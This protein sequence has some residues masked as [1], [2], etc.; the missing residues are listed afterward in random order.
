MLPD[1]DIVKG[2]HPGLILER[3][4]NKQKIRKTQL[5]SELGISNGIITDITKQRRG[6]NPALSIHL[7]RIFEVGEEYFSLLQTYYAL[8]QEHKK[9]IIHPNL[10]LRSSLF[11]DVNL[12]DIDY[13]RN[14]S[15]VIIRVFERGKKME[16][17]RVIDYYGKEQVSQ[18]IRSAKSLLSTAI[19]NA[20]EFLDITN[21]EFKCLHNSTRKQYRTAYI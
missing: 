14:K 19:E 11:W 1:I 13:E 17:K 7:G 9:Q 18:I 10:N 12:K 20:K 21:K 3:E 4:L 2:V 8:K 6:I 16:I 15:F 5:A